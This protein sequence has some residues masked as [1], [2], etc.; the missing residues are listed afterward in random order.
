METKLLKVDRENIDE[1]KIRIGA[2]YIKKGELVAMPTE[3]VYGLGVNG[4][5]PEAV[6]KVFIAK[7]RP[8]D[9]PLILHISNIDQVDK[10]VKDVKNEDYRLMEYLWPGPI[11]MVFKKKDIVPNIVSG[12]GDTVGL[13]LPSNPIA[14]KLIDLSGVPIAAPSANISGRPSP[15]NAEDVYNDM[16]GRI[17][18]IIDGGSSDIGIESTV[19]DMTSKDPIILRPG[20]Y[21]LEYLKEFM[22]NIKMD[23]GLKEGIPKSPGQKYKHYAPKA[24]LIVFVGDSKKVR[25]RIIREIEK[26][27]KKNSKIGVMSFI[28]DEPYNVDLELKIGS[29][30]DIT[31]MG[32]LLFKNL[33]DFDKNN[34]DIIFG[35]G[36][37]EEGYGTSIMNRLKKA[38]AG[39]VIYVD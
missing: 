27:R 4:L 23:L 38:S 37:I 20:F 13:R 6:K 19:V 39:N 14:R 26:E 24:K 16:K 22:P 15:T 36:V 1:D 28:E 32:H 17:A 2:E 7:G 3:T 29:F 21:T 33:R 12:G 9:N 35:V 8:Q 11:T 10:L 34:I 18:R 5:D 30:K 25:E 31:E